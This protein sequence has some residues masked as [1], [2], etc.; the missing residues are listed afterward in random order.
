MVFDR[1]VDALWRMI[2]H[3]CPR[4]AADVACAYWGV[5]TLLIKIERNKISQH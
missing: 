3:Y 5:A 4:L 2:I 1:R